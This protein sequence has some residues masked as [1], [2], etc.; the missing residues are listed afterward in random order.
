MAF[1]SYIG[2]LVQAVVGAPATA[3]SAGF[4]A[5]TYSLTIGQITDVSEMGDTHG[6]IT[7]T[8]LATGR[9]AHI[10]GAADGGE[11]TLTFEYEAAGDAGQQMLRAQ[12]GGNNTV[13][14]KITDPDGKLSYFHAVVANFRDKARSPTNVKGFTVA[15][16]VNTDIIRPSF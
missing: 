7:T 9:T 5:L 1:R 6:D 15:L 14:F 10:N 12:N 13:S 11:V 8:L 3:D 4:A 16:R 2:C